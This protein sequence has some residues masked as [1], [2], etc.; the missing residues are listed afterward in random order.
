ME[1]KVF[2]EIKRTFTHD[3][4]LAYPD[5]NKRFNIHMDISNCQ[6]GVMIIQEVKPISFYS[7]KFAE[8]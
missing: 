5:F 4:L 7:Y 3:T 8:T 6:L 2:D 1:Q